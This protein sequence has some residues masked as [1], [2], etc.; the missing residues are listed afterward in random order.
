MALIV[1]SPTHHICLLNLALDHAVGDIAT[2]DNIVFLDD[3]N[4]SSSVHGIL[5]LLI[6]LLLRLL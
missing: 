5:T 3:C 1:K 4:S 6:Q 2:H